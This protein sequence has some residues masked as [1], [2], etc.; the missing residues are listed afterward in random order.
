MRSSALFGAIVRRR[1]WVLAAL[2]VVTVA[3]AL[4]ASRVRYDSSA[5]IWFLDDDPNLV[6]YRKFL[7]RFP[8]D[9]LGVVGVFAPDVFEA[10]ALAAIGRITRRIERQPHVSRV[11]SLANVRLMESEEGVLE[12]RPLLARIPRDAA[13]RRALRARALASPLLRGQL[14]AADG[15]A[16]AIVFE[17]GP[18][19]SGYEEKAALVR[20]LR[21]IAREESQGEIAVR[22]AGAPSLAVAMLEYAR[23]DLRLLGPVAILAV[24]LVVFVMFRR[25]STTLI[26]L[27]V[28][29]LA[30]TWTFGVMGA[31]GIKV[32]VVSAALVVLLLAVGVANAVHLVVEYNHERQAG[33][34]PEEGARRSAAHLLQ[35]CLYTAITD[36]AGMLSLLLS[37]LRPLREF[38]WLSALGVGFTF[39]ISLTFVPAVLAAARVR[40]PLAAREQSSSTGRV[41]LWLA[42]P[43]PVRRFAVVGAALLL[44]VGAGLLLP[45]IEVGTS[46]VSYFRPGDPTRRDIEAIDRALGGS[47]GLEILVS[48]SPGGLADPRQLARLDRFQRWLGSL[49]GVAS[50]VS[51]VDYLRELYRVMDPEGA[52]RAGGLPR[53]RELTAQL[54]LLMESEQGL[55]ALVRDRYSVGRMSARVSMSDARELVRQVPRIEERIRRDFPG[56]DLRVE[57]TGLAKVM[58]NMEQYLLRSQVSSLSASLLLVAGFMLLMLRSLRLALFAMLPNVAPVFL[59][60]G[61][62]ALLGVALDP[63]T[64]MISSVAMGIVVDD[65]IHFMTRLREHAREGRSLERSLSG[66]IL[67]IG[68]PVLVTSLV[69]AAGFAVLGLGSYTPNVNF[70]LLSAAVMGLA[71]LGDLVF[72]PAALLVVGARLRLLGRAPAL[73]EAAASA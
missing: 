41:L 45:R 38:G 1:G 10:R 18:S 56:A 15:R 19:G 11:R 65:T 47:I 40:A 37:D 3:A 73:A 23:H 25:G 60:L 69:L 32:N 34:G 33:A 24:G 4:L 12:A 29:L 64:V 58:S 42:S 68:R 66:T 13:E 49:P 48:A 53:G 21:G 44:L 7:E 20:Q 31:L 16:A 57:L 17:V 6:A 55:D 70:G 9:Q 39:V 28:V 62:M 61:L 63:G 2:A 22:H 36:A 52:A 46:P 59:G 8:A 67:E 30:L 27:A 50:T 71:L 35:P 14:V 72:L 51:L 54:L 43:S 5:E 26:P